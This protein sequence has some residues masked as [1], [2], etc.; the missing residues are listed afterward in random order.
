MSVIVNVLESIWEWIIE[1]LWII[2]G[3]LWL[4]TVFIM[5]GFSIASS[6]QQ[7]TAECQKFGKDWSYTDVSLTSAECV[8]SNGDIK[9]LKN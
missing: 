8:N 2:L 7:N 5:L 9:Y 4:A 6:E 3:L 1:N